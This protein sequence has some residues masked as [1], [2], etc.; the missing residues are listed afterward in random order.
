M[1][2]YFFDSTHHPTPFFWF[3]TSLFTLYPMIHH[4]S[5]NKLCFLTPS[6]FHQQIPIL[7]GSTN[8]SPSNHPFPFQPSLPNPLYKKLGPRKLKP[9]KARWGRD[10]GHLKKMSFRRVW[11]FLTFVDDY[12]WFLTIDGQKNKKCLLWAGCSSEYGDEIRRGGNCGVGV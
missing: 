8:P 4:H 9:D 2:S 1:L 3:P 12:W 7:P 10:L 5:Y 6:G 11:P